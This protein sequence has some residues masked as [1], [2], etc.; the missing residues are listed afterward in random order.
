M[1][2]D[3]ATHSFYAKQGYFTPMSPHDLRVILQTALDMLELLTCKHSV[4]TPGLSYVLQPARW[5]RMITIYHDRS[6][7]RKR[8]R[9]QVLLHP[10]PRTTDIFRSRD[11]LV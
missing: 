11:P 7:D 5:N 6:K 10:R 8:F 2:V 1:D 9:H 4:V 3:E